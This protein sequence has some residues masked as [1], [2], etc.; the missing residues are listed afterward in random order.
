MIMKSSRLLNVLTV[1]LICSFISC[2]ANKENLKRKAEGSRTLGEAYFKAG[3]HTNALKEFLKAEQIN[4]YDPFLQNDLGLTYLS[5]NR[6]DLAIK[7]FQKAVEIKP[8]F[9]PAINSLGIAYLRN[10]EYDKAIEKFTH[11]TN[12]LIYVTPHFP[13]VNLGW[14]YYLK[15]EYE[16]SEKYYKEALD[17]EPRYVIAMRGL[18][19]TYI[20]LGKIDEAKQ[21]LEKAV[22]IMPKFTPA[23]LELAEACIISGETESARRHLNK[24]IELSPDS[25]MAKDARKKLENLSF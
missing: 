20:K 25:P 11:L 16:K 23:Y 21:I 3:K 17:L 19:R 7:H 13:L 8:D 5:K 15:N 14:V 4:P 12:N 6:P 22:S 1:I 9:A 2:T 18:G 24:V 10:G